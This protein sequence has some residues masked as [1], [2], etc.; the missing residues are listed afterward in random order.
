MLS[1]E[2]EI[3]VNTLLEIIISIKV[4]LMKFVI[5]IITDLLSL[6]LVAKVGAKI[7]VRSAYNQR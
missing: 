4:L 6:R 1:I 3:Q 7:N 2:P 5:L